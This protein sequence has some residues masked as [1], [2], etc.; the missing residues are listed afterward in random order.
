M[1]KNYSLNRLWIVSTFFLPGEARAKTLLARED[2]F[3]LH[4]QYSTHAAGT[5]LAE[6]VN[7]ER[8]HHR[9]EQT[10]PANRVFFFSSS[11]PWRKTATSHCRILPFRLFRSSLSGE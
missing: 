3:T 6:D 1:Q 10:W 9:K 2:L 7:A 11:L 8:C 5:L 4:I